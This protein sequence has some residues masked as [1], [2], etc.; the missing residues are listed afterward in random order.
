MQNGERSVAAVL[1]AAELYLGKHAHAALDGDNPA[2]VARELLAGLLEISMMELRRMSEHSLKPD[3]VTAYHNYLERYARHEPPAYIQGY[4]YFYGYKMFCAPGV[5][6][7][8]PDT[9][10]SVV[11]ALNILKKKS[12]PLRILDLCTGTGCIAL[13]LAL[14]LK[15]LSKQVEV[16]GVDISPEALQ[17]AQRNCTL[18]EATDCVSFIQ[19]D[20]F[21][22][23][24]PQRFDLIISNP[25]YIQTAVIEELSLSVR[26]YEPDIALDGGTDGLL[27]VKRIIAE[28]TGWLMPGAHLIIEHGYDQKA[29]LLQFMQTQADYVE[30]V[31][32]QDLAGRDRVLQTKFLP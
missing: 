30:T 6:I 26:A 14:E 21:Q 5:L 25:P 2:T 27:L 32:L 17:S 19:S 3:Q 16:V 1:R 13:A 22:E 31:V 23:L 7:P 15:K 20:L 29:A 18:H 28:A 4:T 11:A 24:K 12:G 8:R 9:E 10:T